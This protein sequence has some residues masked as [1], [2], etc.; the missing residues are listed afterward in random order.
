MFS[1]SGIAVLRLSSLVVLACFSASPRGVATSAEEEPSAKKA[2]PYQ[3]C[4]L[5]CLTVMARMRDLDIPVTTLQD[6]L[7]PRENGDCS[8]ADLERAA[9]AAGLDPTSAL[10]AWSALPHVPCPCIVQLRSATRFGSRSHFVVLMGLHRL[11]VILLDAPNPAILHPY[12]EFKQ[13]WT[14]VVVAFPSDES[15][16]RALIASFRGPIPWSA[17]T[18]SGA[19]AVAGFLT[20]RL[21]GRGRRKASLPL[22]PPDAA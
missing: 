7:R 15:E 3:C 13:D 21:A 6:L 18:V 5:N 2:D 12:D 20:W 11:G 10:L 9:K 22:S 16:Q 17:L 8:V 14:G 4:G 1:S 19:L